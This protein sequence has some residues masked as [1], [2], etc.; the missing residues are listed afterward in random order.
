M[1]LHRIK[2]FIK[3]NRHEFIAF[4]LFCLIT[5]TVSCFHEC[6]FDELHSWA[7][8]KDNL[9]NIIFSIPH[10]EG[11]PP[12]WYLL[13]KIFNTFNFSP[14][15][16]LKIPNLI[17]MF[18]A[19]WILIFKS[20]FPKILRLTLPFTYYLIYQYSIVS[21]PYCILI[22][23][24]FL[25]GMLHKNRDKHP[26]KYVAVLSIMAMSSIYG[27][28]LSTS[29]AILWAIDIITKKIHIKTFVTK[30]KRFFALLFLCLFCF[31]I[32]LIIFPDSNATATTRFTHL[33]K[34]QRLVYFIVGLPADAVAF[35]VF[36]YNTADNTNIFNLYTD[37]AWCFG[38]IFMLSVIRI[39]IHN[40]RL[41]LL[42]F[43]YVPITVFMAK[44]YIH[45][46]HIGI[47]TIIFIYIF[48]CLKEENEQNDILMNNKLLK[49]YIL[50]AIAIQIYYSTYSII[51]DIKWPYSSSK[52]VVNYI[53]EHNL[54]NYNIAVVPSITWFPV[55]IDSYFNDNIFLTYN[56]S[57][58]GKFYVV[59]N[60]EIYKNKLEVYAT[61]HRNGDI[62]ILISDKP[63][64]E[65]GD[66]DYN[67]FEL[68]KHFCY[69]KIYKSKHKD[70]EIYIYMNRN[71]TLKKDSYNKEKS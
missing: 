20:P 25:A 12:F 51:T 7:I 2:D 3:L 65:N 56:K 43:L 49:Y 48:W 6:W 8:A 32:S 62:D 29:I 10:F 17:I 50:F 45:P 14:D 27:M 13:L 34:W 54:Q 18:T 11:F 55:E 42:L 67:R 53:K 57:T 71:L 52:E 19:I 21:R 36:N 63:L 22:L 69:G 15:F 68:L 5:I 58:L 9:Y 28:I 47:I 46:H 41:N 66:F 64:Y 31:S 30:D 35:N 1:N 33:I 16:G 60:T 59:H 37:V 40:K 24:L 23:G 26:L 38:A 61:W 44:C 4:I 39:F 70:D